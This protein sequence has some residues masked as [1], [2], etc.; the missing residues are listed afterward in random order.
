MG[1]NEKK[2]QQLGMSYGKA[3]HQLRKFILFDLLCSLNK[4]VCYQ[5]G[6]KILHVNQLSIEHKIPWLDS[7]NP[8]ELFFDL[9][10]IAFSHLS[11]NSQAS[12][13]RCTQEHREYLAKSWQGKRNPNNKLSQYD[14]ARIKL[15]LK[16]G[17][18]AHS[19]AKEYGVW[20]TTI[21]DI[22]EGKT[23]V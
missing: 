14:V 20:H 18:S 15:A 4:N 3:S 16:Q 19:I 6:K 9:N 10:N 22:K 2:N 11:C 1:H 13:P 23:W 7:Q 17:Q 12:R 8:V 5:C 21:L